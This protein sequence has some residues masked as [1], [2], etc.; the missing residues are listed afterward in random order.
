M[1]SVMLKNDIQFVC[2]KCDH[3]MKSVA[4]QYMA[5]TSYNNNDVT[6]LL[7]TDVVA[8]VLRHAAVVMHVI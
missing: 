8:M 7:F 5:L 4:Y 2:N 1:T 6:V 3:V